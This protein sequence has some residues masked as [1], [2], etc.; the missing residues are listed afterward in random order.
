MLLAGLKNLLDRKRGKII[1]LRLSTRAISQDLFPKDL[2]QNSYLC[3]TLRENV[4]RGGYRILDWQNNFG[5]DPNAN[6]VNVFASGVMVAN[7]IEA[8][9]Q[10]R[11]E[12][13]FVN[14]INLTSPDLIYRGWQRARQLQKEKLG[15]RVSYQLEKL[16]PVS[17]RA[18]PAVTVLDGHSH[19]MA[20]I[21]SILG[22]K[23]ISLGVDEFGQ[24]GT[25]GDLYDHYG[26]GTADI[27]M[28]CR[29][30]LE[31]CPIKL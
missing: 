5:Y 26:I 13:L 27:A 16:V 12:G 21:G 25:R 7:A 10:L 8:A 28:A 29:S 30:A 2:L 18:V 15:S 22:T 23:V 14:V 4:L 24:S 17:E 19:T 1:Y 31:D 3:K 11:T 20:F 9:N 6:V